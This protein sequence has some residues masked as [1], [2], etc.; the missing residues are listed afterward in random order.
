MYLQLGTL[1]LFT[2]V[3]SA[4]FSFGLIRFNNRLM[5]TASPRDDRWHRNPTPNSGGVAIFLSCAVVYLIALSHVHRIVAIGAAAICVLGFVDDRI[6]LRPA[7]KFAAQCLIS[8]FVVL[9][10]VVFPATPWH[11]PNIFLTL[12]WIV[13]ITNAFNL[14]DNMDGLC[15]GVAIIICVFRFWLLAV[16]GYWNDAILGAV[17]AAGFVGFL[18]F[19]YRPAKIFM[20]DC[21]SMFAGFSLASLAI[22]SPLPNTRIFLAG[23]FCP[24]L[25]FTYPIFDTLLVSVL[26]RAAGRKISVG[27]RDHSSHRLA[28]LGIPEQK[29]VWILWALT[30]LG[31]AI[32]AAARWMPIQVIAGIAILAGALTMF[33]VFL[34][35]V[36]PYQFPTD[37]PLLRSSPLRR[38]I[39]T[40]RAGLIIIV[41]MLAA[42]LSL[43]LAFLIRY[44]AD[45]PPGQIR[46]LLISLPVVMICHGLL[47][48]TGKTFNV[49]WRW[50][51]LRDVLELARAVVLGAA[52]AFFVLWLSGVRFYPRGVVVLY[53]VLCLGYC[54]ALRIS[55]R[56]FQDLFSG[57]DS[58]KQRIA[59]LGA[60][61]QGEMAA[62]LM[63]KHEPLN[64]LPVVF[65][66]YD[67]AKHGMKMRGIP[68]RCCRSVDM[69]TLAAE[70]KL[71][72][73]LMLKTPRFDAEHEKL[74]RECREA[75]L[76]LRMLNIAIREMDSGIEFDTADTH[77]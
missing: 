61:S 24:A 20:G 29:V 6:Q 15:A 75:G 68:I 19:N 67:K 17:I 50:F 3:L 60:D 1:V 38:F 72:A 40:L 31:S 54:I 30:A 11:I 66:D 27:G 49:V 36:P 33:A 16:D 42:G 22:A 43:F 4:L 23:V 34:S 63:E 9:S 44:E 2:A 52:S 69:Q 41:D 21:G 53:C 57:Q 39:P 25:A 47:S 35:T 73:V 58:S 18:V 65:L 76:Q 71:E 28:S 32:G 74:E 45:I 46:N 26:R 7:V 56:V 13:G 62:A 12:L 37:S 59:I 70:F 14:I 5:L 8:L 77:R 55:L 48:C 64:T 51:C 10:G